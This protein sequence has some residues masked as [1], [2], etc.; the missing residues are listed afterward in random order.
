MQQVV[1]EKVS[2][3]AE[4]KLFLAQSAFDK[5]MVIVSNKSGSALKICLIFSGSLVKTVLT[6]VMG[7]VNGSP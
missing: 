4:L 1:V 6:P 3:H 5:E 2:V 7:M